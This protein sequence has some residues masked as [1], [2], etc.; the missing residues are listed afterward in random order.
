MTCRFVPR[1]VEYD[2]FAGTVRTACSVERSD[3]EDH[4]DDG[5]DAKQK[6][7]SCS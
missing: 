7:Q 3:V 5:D 1:R 4:A 2:A 6:Q